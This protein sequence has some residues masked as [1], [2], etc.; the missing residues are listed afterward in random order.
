LNGD[1]T[2]SRRDIVAIGGSA[3]AVEAT[4]QLLRQL[5]ADLPAAVVLTIH[6]GAERPSFLPEILEADGPL[7]AVQAEEGME[8]RHGRVHVAPPDRHLLIGPGHLHVRRGPKENRTR[9]AIDP[10]FRSAAVTLSTQV[11]GII[12]SGALDDGTAGLL[13]IRRCGG[14]GVAQEPK[15]ARHPGMPWSAIRAGAVDHV[16]PIRLM[17]PLLA[18]LV[19]EPAPPPPVPP[20]RLRMEALI[21]A[22]ELRMKPDHDPVGTLSPLTCPDCHG[23]LREINDEGFLRFRCHTGHAFSAESL[24]SA[25]TDAW[26]RAL[27]DAQRV[28]E[29]QLALL[30][31]MALDAIDQGRA[32]H[33]R[34]YEAR[35]RGYEEGVEII[36]GLLVGNGQHGAAPLDPVPDQ[37][38]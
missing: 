24:R 13:T 9:P 23:A 12:F 26:E 30:R 22:Q 21:A 1:R 5:P 28:Q 19:T 14:I 31:R 34:N 2:A 25:Q 6:R 29:E 38:A 37:P 36:R 16:C 3:G 15:E 20:E 27:Y 4:R 8:L 35:A 17:A 18:R 11:I 10:M 7:R 33:A 32:E